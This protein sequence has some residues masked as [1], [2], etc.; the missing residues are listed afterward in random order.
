MELKIIPYDKNT[1]PLSAILI[2]GASAITWVKALQA[3]QLVLTNIQ[4]YPIPN[5]TPN[6]LWGCLAVTNGPLDKTQ[7]GR[8]ELCQVVTPN[9][10]IPEKSAL[11]PA[12]TE[13]E[14]EKMFSSGRHIIHPD[15][16]L[17]E[18]TEEVDFNT[19]VAGFTQQEVIVTKPAPSTFIPQ[20]IRSFHIQTPPPEEVLK[21]L[22]ENIFPKKENMQNKP[23]SL[24]EKLKLQFYRTLFT[25][26]KGEG[27]TPASVKP[28]SWGSRLAGIMEKLF[29]SKNRFDK[30]LMDFEDLEK[31]NQKH[32]E[33]LMDMLKNDPE[34]A[35]K[36]AI[37]LDEHGAGRGSQ[38]PARFDFAR[39]WFDFSLTGDHHRSGGGG[40][41]S[42][43]DHFHLLQKQY[44]ETAEALVK[45]NEH[46][47]AAF[48][49]LKL[50]K[51]PLQAAETLEAGK[52]YAEAA[53]IFLKQCNN[54]QRAAQCYEKG[55]MTMDAIELYKEL[56]DHEKVGDLYMT[57]SNRTEA[58]VHYQKVADNFVKL[59]QYVKAS[60][61]YKHK[62]DDPTAGQSMLRKG[63]DSNKDAVN[64]LN[65]YFANIDDVEQLEKEIKAVS[66]E[67]VTDQNRE[68]FL[69]VLQHE[70][71]KQKQLREPL[72]ELAYELVATHIAINPSIVSRLNEFN[73]E[74]KEL[75]KD[76]LRF[77]L[78]AKKT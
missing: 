76:T 3:L 8:H 72:T 56:S 78:N 7:A 34:E 48:V 62:M 15:F 47:K 20:T 12:M 31:R 2:R 6:V 37:P 75:F 55:N 69:T 44:R 35:L 1:Y 10:F 43:G 74:N 22:T 23:L 61:F 9:L 30:L 26:T 65:N 24:F 53:T 66:V 36:Y 29:P 11:F 60:L 41:V 17:V 40:T 39:R 18:L 4:V 59:D 52:Y 21:N 19:L 46:Q 54:K 42:I 63:W 45:K 27:N 58:F 73:P 25:K 57:V 71:K 67:S 50:L 16:G 5:V 28:T 51:N 33:R 14:M 49:Y 70:Y 13:G 77:K 64:C 68:S 32:V 38:E